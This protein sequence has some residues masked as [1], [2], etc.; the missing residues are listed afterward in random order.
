LSFY[1]SLC[2]TKSIIH[3][4]TGPRVLSILGPAGK[5]Y[6]KDELIEFKV[7]L[8]DVGTVVETPSLAFNFGS[9]DRT[10]AYFSGGGNLQS[11][12]I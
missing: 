9:K 12:A 3:D 11:A 1:K 2:V 6:S 4:S 10:A 8:S 7:S 5:N